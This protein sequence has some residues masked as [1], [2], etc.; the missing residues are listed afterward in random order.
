[1]GDP[2]D[3][4]LLAM[5]QEPTAVT[6]QRKQIAHDIAMQKMGILAAGMINSYLVSV[7]KHLTKSEEGS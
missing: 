6:V 7:E 2:I 5:L 1:M 3:A 4:Q